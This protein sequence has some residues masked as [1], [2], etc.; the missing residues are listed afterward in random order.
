MFDESPGSSAEVDIC[1]EQPQ[2]YAGGLV[3]EPAASELRQDSSETCLT[4]RKT[5]RKKYGESLKG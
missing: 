5:N 2:D 1:V 3:V 4:K